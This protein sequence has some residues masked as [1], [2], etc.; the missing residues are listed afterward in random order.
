MTSVKV[1]VTAF[2]EKACGVGVIDGKEVFVPFTLPGE[3][4]EGEWYTSKK[5][6]WLNLELV[7][8]KSTERVDPKCVH[9]GSCGG[10]SLQHVSHEFYKNFKKDLVRNALKK[11]GIQCDSL[12]PVIVGERQR[13]RIDFKATN[14]NGQVTMGFT[15]KNR[16]K[17]IDFKECW[18]VTP[19]IESVLSPLRDLLTTITEDHMVIH[20]FIT[21]AAN[22]LDMILSGFK[23]PLSQD[24]MRFVQAFAKNHLIRL[25]LKIKGQSA[26]VIQSEDPYVLFAGN[27]VSISANC[28]LQA[29]AKAD[30]ILADIVTEHLPKNAHKI[31]DLFC[32]RGTL[33][34]PIAEKG[35]KV[36]GFEGDVRSIAALTDVGHPNVRALTQDLFGNPVQAEDL[37]QFQVIVM[38]PPRSGAQGQAKQVAMS[39]APIVIYVSCSPESFAKEAAILCEKGYIL[40]KVIPVDQFMWA[41]HTEVVGIFRI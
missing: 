11:Q 5:H 9:Y 22:G 19:E 17:T 24:H 38:N 18:I 1:K 39:R 31:V 23:N 10:C 40:D 37:K 21:A 13:R 3:E 27:K 14:K 7:V 36:T 28:F 29:S 2:N 33:T 16:W 6:H 20:I 32:G 8:Q 15:I 12:D 25:T 35:H 34:L 30:Q 41:A 26:T 4:V